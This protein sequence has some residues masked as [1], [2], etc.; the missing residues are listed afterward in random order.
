MT[1]MLSIPAAITFRVKKAETSDQHVT[2]T[3]DVTKLPDEIVLRLLSHGAAAAGND[4]HSSYTTK[5]ADFNPK[6][7]VSFIE[8][9]VTN[10]QNGKW[11]GRGEGG[12]LV[13]DPLA[14]ELR[15]MAMDWSRPLHTVKDKTVTLTEAGL[16]KAKAAKIDTKDHA[17]ALAALK[18]AYSANE[19]VRA[20]A[21]AAVAARTELDI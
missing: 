20:V 2:Y 13:V 18:A 11:D 1:R 12:G 14:T 15:R 8:S 19:K 9:R 5:L 17:S 10:W 16:A 21:A 7:V 4:A 6:N 3:L